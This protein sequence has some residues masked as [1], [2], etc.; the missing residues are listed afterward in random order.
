MTNNEKKDKKNKQTEVIKLSG[1][2]SEFFFLFSFMCWLDSDPV[3][4][5]KD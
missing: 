5:Q 2:K 3:D 1:R 4:K